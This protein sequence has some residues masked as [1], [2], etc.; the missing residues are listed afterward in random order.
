MA[1]TRYD[2]SEI[3][4]LLRRGE[5]IMRCIRNQEGVQDNSPTAIIYS[6]DAQAGSYTKALENP[7]I[8]EHKSQIGRRLGPL[9][10]DLGPTSLL[11]AGVGEATSLVPILSRMSHPP[12]E[13]FGFDI[14][15]SRLLYARKHLEGHGIK[16]AKLFTGELDRIPLSD[17]AVDVVITMR[18]MEPNR[19]REES[20]LKE[21]LR[22]A[23]RHLV[24]IEPSYELGGPATRDRIEQMGYVSGI[25]QTLKRLGYAPSR[26]ERWGLDFNS[27]NEAALIVVDK[28]VIADVTPPRFVSPISG[29]P[30]VSRADCWFCPED[31]H[32]FPIIAGIPCLT[33]ASGILASKLDQLPS[34]ADEFDTP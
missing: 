28:A 7:N 3:S 11:D 4:A 23:R 9:L 10:D 1:V 18:A 2:S 26:F 14:S 34:P 13:V 12:R 29:K 24:L 33:L 17:S 5:N 21:L 27:S 16:E 6:Y 32:A 19:G 22:V 30:L 31:G 15:L 25:P 20:I 8:Q